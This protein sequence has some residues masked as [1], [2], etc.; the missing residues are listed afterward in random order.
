MNETIPENPDVPVWAREDAFPLAPDG[1][2][3]M[4]SK[5]KSHV[6][7]SRES[8]IAAIRYDRD[9][10]VTLVWAPGHARMILPEELEGT[11]DAMRTARAQWTRDD[12]ADASH[13]LR[14]FGMILLGFGGYAFYSGFMLSKR[15]AESAGTAGDVL[16]HLK[17]AAMTMVRSTESGLA[18][19][20]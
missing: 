15:L 18:L 2:G 5:G 7:D 3:W 19:L 11:G 9:S 4:D 20:M 8:L 10:S 14:W 13:K 1:W 16:Q 17:F 6:C 12:Y